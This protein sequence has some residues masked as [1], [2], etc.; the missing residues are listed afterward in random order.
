MKHHSTFQK[1]ASEFQKHRYKAQFDMNKSQKHPA[2]HWKVLEVFLL[3]AGHHLWHVCFG[4]LL[5]HD[6]MKIFSANLTDQLLFNFACSIARFA[7]EITESWLFYHLPG[8]WVHL[9]VTRGYQHKPDSN[10]DKSD[11]AARC[12]ICCVSCYSCVYAMIVCLGTQF[13]EGTGGQAWDV[14]IH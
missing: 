9:L 3:H 14:Y 2:L 1:A 12:C 10:P 13:S 7:R 6:C 11:T 8:W 5:L 4:W